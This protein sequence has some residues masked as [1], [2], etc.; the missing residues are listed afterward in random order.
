MCH[1]RGAEAGAADDLAT[2]RA[3]DGGLQGSPVLWLRQ[4]PGDAGWVA[5]TGDALRARVREAN[6]RTGGSAAADDGLD[7]FEHTGHL[8]TSVPRSDGTAQVV[9]SGHAFVQNLRGGHYELGL[10]APPGLRM[11]AT[12]ANSRNSAA[13][14]HLTTAI[15]PDRVAGAAMA[16]GFWS[17]SLRYATRSPH[18]MST[19]SRVTVD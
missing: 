2:G 8:D 7:V 17:G 10:D 15:S 4:V 3:L 18:G 16:T 13:S 14:G 12:S 19:G 9:T 1:V 11:A 6:I 5:V